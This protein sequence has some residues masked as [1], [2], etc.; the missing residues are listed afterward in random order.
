MRIKKV[1]MELESASVTV[2]ENAVEIL[3]FIK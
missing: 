3:I 1:L 2:G